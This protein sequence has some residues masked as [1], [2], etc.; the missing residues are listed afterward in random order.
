[1][2]TRRRFMGALSVLTAACTAGLGGVI[3]QRRRLAMGELVPD[4][5]IALKG[6][7]VLLNAAGG[8]S[9]RG[10]LEDVTA[11]RRPGRFGA[12]TTVQ[13]S[14]LVEADRIDAPAGAYRLET[15]DVKLDR[16]D[17]LPVGGN[18]RDRR[19]EAVITRIV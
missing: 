13:I 8:G 19:L 2:M 11:V 7:E 15:D 16:L 5:M 18:G 4:S 14:L 10:V 17:F 12:P 9:L 6:S 1:M 3:V